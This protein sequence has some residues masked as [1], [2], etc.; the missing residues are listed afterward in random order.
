LA[1]AKRKSYAD[2]RPR[3]PRG[4]KAPLGVYISACQ[5][6]HFETHILPEAMENGWPQSIDF[7]KVP[8]RVEGIKSAL[9]AIIADADNCSEDDDSGDVDS[10]GPRI[11]SVFW[12]EVKKEIK[13]Q[14]SR[15][16]TGV[17]G[18]FASFEKTQPG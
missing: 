3:N 16:V 9:E 4:L 8:E 2:P 12:R 6:H 17:K 10:R 14:G 13:K 15:T 7:K 18:Q 1:T 5:R 11:R